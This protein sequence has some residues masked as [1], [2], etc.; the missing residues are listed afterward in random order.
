MTAPPLTLGAAWQQARAQAAAAGALPDPLT[1]LLDPAFTDALWEYEGSKIGPEIPGALHPK[2]VEALTQPGKHRW[3]FWG[4]QVGK[5]TLGAVDTVL[6]ALGRH[7]LQRSGVLPPPPITAWASALSWELWQNTLL[8]ELLTW[9]PPHRILRAPPPKQASTLR[10]IV[11]RADNGAESR[12]TGKSAEAGAEAYQSARVHS[13]WLDEEHPEAVWD[14]MQPRLLRYGGRTLATMTPL[15]GMTWVHG[16]VYDPVKRGVIPAA[17]HWFSHAGLADNPAITPEALEEL[18]HELR[19]NPSQLAAREHGYFVRPLGAV[20]PFDLDKHG[21]D[22]EG[23]A[24]DAFVRRTA[25]YG[26]VDLGK[27]RF[28]FAWGGV[29]ADGVLTMVDEVFSQNETSD[30]RA[31]KIHQQLKAYGVREIQIW[32]D[33]ADPDGLKE[34]NEAFERLDSPYR[35]TAVDMANKARSAG[36]LRVESLLTR[37]ALRVRRAM[38]AG[39]VWRLG[40]SAGSFGKPVE[41][42]RWIWEIQNWQYPKMPDGKVQ[43]DDPD[44]ATADGADMMDGFRY[45]AMT[46]LGPLERATVKRGTTIHEQL[47]REFDEMRERE[48]TPAD[49]RGGYTV[50]RQ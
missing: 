49:R 47:K 31:N 15:K 50:I 1:R 22:L 10:D 33:C 8:P 12:I 26:H 37:G 32:G 20:Y 17:R 16:R 28:A 46:W 23:D 35:V 48:T 5:T 13:V 38:G 29:D 19:N 36:I 2:Q 24:L 27:W 4:N 42:S 3:L 45:L 11:L 9:I 34:L 25:H 43:K 40:M 41:G 18:R 39:H 7:P 30:V 14:E 44:D 21:T 6:L